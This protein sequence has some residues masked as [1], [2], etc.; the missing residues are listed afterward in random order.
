MTLEERIPSLTH[1]PHSPGPPPPFFI[2]FHV[3]FDTALCI[4]W[5]TSPFTSLRVLW[6]LSDSP[7]HYYMLTFPLS[8]VASV[9]HVCFCDILETKDVY[10]VHL[11]SVHSQESH[12]GLWSLETPSVE[13]WIAQ[14]AS[15]LPKVVHDLLVFVLW[16]PLSAQALHLS[17]WTWMLASHRTFLPGFAFP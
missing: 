3:G 12:Q 6:F 7:S 4:L 9:G 1:D 8:F 11:K 15:F 14:M 10:L 17:V 13:R 2:H 5:L 16:S